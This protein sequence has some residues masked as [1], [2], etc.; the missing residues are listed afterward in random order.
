MVNQTSKSKLH[1]K[2]HLNNSVHL[3]DPLVFSSSDANPTITTCVIRGAQLLVRSLLVK[4]KA[5]EEGLFPVGVRE[6][7]GE[8]FQL[9]LWRVKSFSS[10]SRKKK[11]GREICSLLQPPRLTSIPEQSN[12]DELTDGWRLV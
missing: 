8:E 7:A 9:V 6:P 1:Q 10:E 2:A 5:I 12:G 4:Q 3:S 11:P